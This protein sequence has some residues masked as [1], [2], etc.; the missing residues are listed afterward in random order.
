LNSQVR[1][2]QKTPNKQNKMGSTHS[3]SHNVE[4]TTTTTSPVT[5][6]EDI[7][8]IEEYINTYLE[9]RNVHTLPREVVFQIFD[10]AGEWPS[11]RISSNKTIYGQNMNHLQLVSQQVP[12]GTTCKQI[13]VIVWSHDQ[14]WSSYPKN[15]GTYNGSW[16]WGEIISIPLNLEHT[17]QQ[18]IQYQEQFNN[19]DEG[20]TVDH[21]NIITSV[22]TELDQSP[23]YPVYCNLVAS[24]HWQRHVKVF[25][26]NH[27]LVQELKSGDRVGLILRSLYPGWQNHVKWCQIKLSYMPDE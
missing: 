9:R 18:Q 1:V 16:T 14:G 10:F 6:F 17:V 7:K 5:T 2:I 25:D 11:I 3:S 27:K 8:R 12:N 26:M 24:S 23:R 19:P 20:T 15:H 21:G 4:N 22:P 13:E